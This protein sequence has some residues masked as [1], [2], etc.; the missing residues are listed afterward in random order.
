ML[1][2]SVTL[3]STPKHSQE[4]TSTATV[5]RRLF[6][7]TL[8]TSG[9]AKSPDASAKGDLCRKAPFD[10]DGLNIKGPAT[11]GSSGITQCEARAL[12]RRRAHVEHTSMKSSMA[13]SVASG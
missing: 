3:R 7:R 2:S 4:D 11:A 12:A 13:G 8:M 6:T 1:R 10:A 5:F 9:H